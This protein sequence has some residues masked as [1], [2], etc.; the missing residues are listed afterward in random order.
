[1]LQVAA[2]HWLVGLQSESW[3]HGGIVV[4]VVVLIV[5]VVGVGAGAQRRPVPL[6]V[7][8]CVPNWSVTFAEGDSF[9]HFTL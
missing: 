9:G 6:T 4:V 8:W 1:L 5:V 2:W 7:T 3:A